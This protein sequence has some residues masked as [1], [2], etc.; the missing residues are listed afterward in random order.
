MLNLGKKK[1]NNL[2]V[3]SCGKFLDFLLPVFIK[4][5]GHTATLVACRWARVVLEVT[6]AWASGQELY[7]QK[8]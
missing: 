7:A 8:A 5:A 3:L 4:M 2:S 6:R 1:K